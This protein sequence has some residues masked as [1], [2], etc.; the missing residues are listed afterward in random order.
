MCYFNLSLYEDSIEYSNKALDI[1][2]NHI[3]SL[4]IK[5]KSLA[6]LYEF[7]QALAIFE[8]LKFEN[9]IQFVK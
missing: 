7:D 5:A 3:K 6:Y 1:D 9:E 4:L 8:W 2:K